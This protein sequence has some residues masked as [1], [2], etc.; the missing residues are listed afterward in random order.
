[1]LRSEALIGFQKKHTSTVKVL[2]GVLFLTM[3]AFLLFGH[4]LL[5]R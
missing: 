1:M 4:R 2:T 5:A 3:A